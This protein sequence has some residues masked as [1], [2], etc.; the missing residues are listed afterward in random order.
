MVLTGVRKECPDRE[1]REERDGFTELRN[2]ASAV[3][4]LPGGQGELTPVGVGCLFL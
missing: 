2:A 3:G 1:Q 4:E